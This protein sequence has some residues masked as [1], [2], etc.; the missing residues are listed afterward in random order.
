VL[1]APGQTVTLTGIGVARI[2]PAPV[3]TGNTVY[4]TYVFGKDAYACVTLDDLKVEYL[5]RPEKTDPA[6]Q[7][8][9]VSYKFYNSTFLKNNAFAMRIESS[10]QFNMTFG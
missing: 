4:P 10:S 5:D 2:P 8:R 9:M 1:L 7:L 6:N 3:A